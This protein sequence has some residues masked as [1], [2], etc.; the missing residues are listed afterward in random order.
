MAKPPVSFGHSVYNRVKRYTSE[1]RQ[2]GR[3]S[4]GRESFECC[5]SKYMLTMFMPWSWNDWWS[6][7]WYI[8]NVLVVG[9][10]KEK[11]GK[12]R[13]RSI[14]F[15]SK[16][17]SSWSYG[18]ILHIPLLGRWRLCHQLVGD[19]VSLLRFK[20]CFASWIP[21]NS[22]FVSEQYWASLLWERIKYCWKLTQG[23]LLHYFLEPAYTQMVWVATM[24]GWFRA[25]LFNLWI[26]HCF[27]FARLWPPV[28]Q[29]KLPCLQRSKFCS[30]PS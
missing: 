7:T 3:W 11:I 25:M 10:P 17:N 27:G 6:T 26:P 18:K 8:G 20:R 2:V 5:C 24:V 28:R 16:Q 30:L 29:A 15:S 23:L 21:F 22:A 14:T 13:H 4:Q 12:M 19:W 9:F 1:I